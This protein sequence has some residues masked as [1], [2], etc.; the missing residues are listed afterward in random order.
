MQ[1]SPNARSKGSLG[2][3]HDGTAIRTGEEDVYC[4]Y[5]CILK[6]YEQRAHH[7]SVTHEGSKYF[8]DLTV[9]Q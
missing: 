7:I 4:K 3:R 5:K 8:V 6:P 2:D 9:R 1:E